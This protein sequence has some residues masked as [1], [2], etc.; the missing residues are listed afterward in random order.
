LGKHRRQQE[1]YSSCLKLE[2]LPRKNVGDQQKLDLESTPLGTKITTSPHVKHIFQ[3]PFVT[4]N[5]E[6]ASGHL[7]FI[8]LVPLVESPKTTGCDFL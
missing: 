4:R 6:V 5:R 8:A 7:H 1:F 2:F 3:A